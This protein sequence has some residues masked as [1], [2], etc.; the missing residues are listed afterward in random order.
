MIVVKKNGS[1]SSSRH[2][3]VVR[4][5][6]TGRAWV[7]RE[8]NN[9]DRVGSF[10][11]R[12]FVACRATYL[13]VHV[14]FSRGDATQQRPEKSAATTSGRRSRASPVH[15][16]AFSLETR[17]LRAGAVHGRGEA[18][19]ACHLLNHRLAL[20]LSVR[21]RHPHRGRAVHRVFVVISLRPQRPSALFRG[22]SRGSRNTRVLRPFQLV[23]IHANL[24]QARGG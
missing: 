17:G 7:A 14:L 2:G 23:F 10:A 3:R 24:Q 18:V 16:P 19:G 5:S 4:K 15:S 6:V 8:F 22:R 13:V 11:M 9:R 1:V 21:P 20:A 12:G